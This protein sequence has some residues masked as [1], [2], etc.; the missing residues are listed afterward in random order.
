MEKIRI[1]R[2]WLEEVGAPAA[3]PTHSDNMEEASIPIL[4]VQLTA[5]AG[6]GGNESTLPLLALAAAN[7][8]G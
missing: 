5:E 3:W 7:L 6:A 8:L 4:T 1:I 2:K